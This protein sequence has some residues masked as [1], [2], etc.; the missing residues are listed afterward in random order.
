MQANHTQSFVTLGEAMG[1]FVAKTPG[2]LSSV[3]EFSRF[4]AGAEVNV[5]VGMARL[6]FES[7]Y[8]SK[9]GEDCIG[10]FICDAVSKENI[11]IQGISKTDAY[12]TGFMMKA[13]VTDG[14]DPSVEYFR[15][16]SAASTLCADDISPDLFKAGTHLHLTGVA[17]AVSE[18]MRSA[19][20][21]ALSYAKAQGCSITFDTNLRPTLWPSKE[22]MIETI[23]ELAFASDVVLPGIEEGLILVGSD[24]PETI[25][26][27][28]INKGVK[29]VIVKLG[30]A[31]AY[32][33]T[34]EGETG[35]VAGFKV[36]K[37]VDT[38]GAG[39]S[40]A[41]GVIS[42]LLD[43]KSVAEAARR[44]NLFGSL[45]VQVSGDSEALPTRAQLI[46]LESA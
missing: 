41:T 21:Q 26:D 38:V 44:G 25:A 29:T 1:L 46:E 36:E 4:L 3:E 7:T 19:V 34:S 14:S 8:V 11:S 18:P 35:T 20:K 10:E 33:K 16:N 40:F 37:V 9:V 17:A 42:A 31:G 6:G 30:S 39:D 2:K 23:N 28:Y 27:F 45:T 13:N 12:P 15:R 32:Y 43:G 22:M 5:A 24:D